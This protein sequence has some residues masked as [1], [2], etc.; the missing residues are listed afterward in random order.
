MEA[1]R[2]SESGILHRLSR[3]TS[4]GGFIPEIDGLR[5]IAIAVVL[6]HHIC[7]I[8]LEGG[9]R[10]GGAVQIPRDWR[11]LSQESTLIHSLWQ[12]YFGVHLFF[13]LSGF[14][15]GLPFVRHYVSGAQ[16]P[17]L[18]N[19]FL[20]RLTRI[21]PPYVLNML[22]CVALL[23]IQNG[24]ILQDTY[25][26]LLA[27]L[28]Y[29]HNAIYSSNSTINGV[30]WSLE[31]E[32]Q[33]YILAPFLALLFLSIRNTLARR[34]V[35]VCA[36]FGCAL[37][38]QKILWATQMEALKMSLAAYMQYFLAGFLLADLYQTGTICSTRRSWL[39]DVLGIGGAAMTL[40]TMMYWRAALYTMLPFLVLV[41]Y[42]GAFQ[43]RLL[44]RFFVARPIV[45]IGGMCYTIYLYHV[46]IISLFKGVMRTI[47]APDLPLWADLG[48]QALVFVPLI[49]VLCSVLFVYTEKPFMGRFFRFKTSES[50][51]SSGR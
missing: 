34:V 44:R 24:P 25:K 38:T 36:I 42:C 49:L 15:L 13:V 3:V 40:L 37:F 22:V 6:L 27:S 17:S 14:V 29:V 50:P 16:K 28:F 12:G 5:F 41:F 33:F 35:L 8:Y 19:Y 7:A 2:A 20:R 9:E 10:F 1:T 18:K 4:S 21:E 11:R 47:A 45:I 23:A 30:A 48:I 32:V 39:W 26:H 43:G 31:I 51:P 46:P